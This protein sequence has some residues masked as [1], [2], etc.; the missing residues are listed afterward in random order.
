MK[1]TEL[2]AIALGAILTNNFIFSQ[3][4]GICPF[5]G[6][7]KKIDTAVGMGAAVTFVMGLASALCYPVNKLL[8]NL[9]LASCRPWPSFWS[10]PVW[11]SSW[12]C[13]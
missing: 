6:V 4:L 1:V 3:F 8:D 2:L 13:S 10:S 12:R 7:S 5:M 11:C 9:G